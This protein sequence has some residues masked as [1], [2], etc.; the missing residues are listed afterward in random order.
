[1]S[2]L[3]LYSVKAVLLLDNEGSRIFAKY[4][5]APLIQQNHAKP[6]KEQLAFEKGLHSKSHKQ[7]KADVMLYDGQIVVY[8]QSVDVFLYIVGSM[9]ENEPMLYQVL[10]GLREALDLILKQSLDK[11]TLLESY[12]L[13]ALAVDECIDSGIILETDPSIIASRVSR[14][15]LHDQP[16]GIR[17]D[18]PE[19]GLMTMFNFAKEKLSERLKNQF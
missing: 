16:M 1:M 15:P 4:Y 17:M 12:D 3:S 18:N 19:Q 14:P 8:K 2:A 10:V 7:P 5:D 6:L 9:D 11:R 13:V